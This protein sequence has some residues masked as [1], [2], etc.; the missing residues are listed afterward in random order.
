[1]VQVREDGYVI[2][3]DVT[4]GKIIEA[5]CV[6]IGCLLIPVSILKEMKRK[7]PDEPFA[8]ITS[9]PGKQFQDESEWFVYRVKRN[10]FKVLVNT[11]VQTLH[12]DK[13]TGQYAAHESVNLSDYKTSIPITTR[14][15]KR[16]ELILF[17]KSE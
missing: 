10:G 12:V 1:M 14:L 17:G 4:P 7:E 2:P 11:N 6:G 13:A 9:E 15:M 8:R 16:P 3:A 5:E